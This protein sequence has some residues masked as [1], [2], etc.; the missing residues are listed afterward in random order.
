MK[1]KESKWKKMKENENCGAALECV[2]FLG[3]RVPFQNVHYSLW[4]QGRRRVAPLFPGRGSKLSQNRNKGEPPQGNTRE[5][6]ASDP[7]ATCEDKFSGEERQVF[8]ELRWR[9]EREKEENPTALS[10]PPPSP[11]VKQ[12]KSWVPGPL[13]T[14]SEKKLEKLPAR[15]MTGVSSMKKWKNEK[16]KIEKMKNELKKRKIGKKNNKN[17]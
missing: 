7:G 17:E 14:T 15:Q 6:P 3:A 8:I 5:R 16:M 2:V 9:D 4:N 1:E 11:C 12:R 13:L 10:P